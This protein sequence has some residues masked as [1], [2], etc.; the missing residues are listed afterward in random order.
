MVR[1][2]TLIAISPP[3]AR[4]GTWSCQENSESSSLKTTLQYLIFFKK[5]L[6]G[7]GCEVQTFT[8]PTACAVFGNPECDCPMDTPCADVLITDMM[9]P[10]MDGIELLR[11][12][13]KRKCKA[14]DANKALMSAI[15][16]PQQQAAVKELGRHFFR[17]PFKLTE[18]KQWLHDCAERI[19]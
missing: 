3:A 6:Q 12:Q 10:N 2:S 19:Q 14:L 7:Y 13:R 18:V 17:K 11:L 15:T 1:R 8:D 4:M 16:T 9:M 5:V